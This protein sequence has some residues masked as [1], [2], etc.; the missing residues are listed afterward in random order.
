AE[1]RFIDAQRPALIPTHRLAA[2]LDARPV[3]LP[4]P[5]PWHRDRRGAQAGGQ[6]S[7]TS[8]MAIALSLVAHACRLRGTQRCLEL[9]FHNGFDRPPAPRTH[10]RL[11]A[12]GPDLRNLFLVAW[13]PGTVLHRVILR[14]PPPSGRSS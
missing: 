2:P 6:R 5:R 11:D 13:L 1:N 10:H 9:L 12:V 14:H 8:T 3:G 7:L 4:H